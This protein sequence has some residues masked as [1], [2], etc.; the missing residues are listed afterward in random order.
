M[1]LL[2]DYL[3]LMFALDHS[4]QVFKHE[5]R[6]P[7]SFPMKIFIYPGEKVQ[8]KGSKNQFSMAFSVVANLN[9]SSKLHDS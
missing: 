2:L 6:L 3:L 8:N 7:F 1:Q 9:R 5:L 4:L